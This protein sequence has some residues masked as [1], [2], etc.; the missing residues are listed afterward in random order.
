[1]HIGTIKPQ[2]GAKPA[3]SL[4]TTERDL[5]QGTG[6]TTVAITVT[7][8]TGATNTEWELYAWH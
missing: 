4:C 6:N 1:M 8:G 3:F 2:A 5:N 7:F